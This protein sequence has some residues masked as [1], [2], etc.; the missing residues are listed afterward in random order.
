MS[1]LSDK[2]AEVWT[3]ILEV[4]AEIAKYKT[5]PFP[6]PV[7]NP[8]AS[9]AELAALEQHLGQVL[10][11][12]YREFLSLHNGVK[13]F[14]LDMPLLA[15]HEIIADEHGWVEDLAEEE[16]ELAKFYIAG[17]DEANA[18]YLVFDQ[19]VRSADGEMEV[20]HL[21]LRLAQTR[22]PSFL[23]MLEDR[24]KRSNRRLQAE[25]ADREQLE[26]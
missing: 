18:G 8:P 11:P 25:R 12:L 7:S 20:V 15:T 3:S 26:D 24:L 16:P 13:N 17:S 2:L 4:E 9:G 21:T 5:T 10:P 14:E 23:Q 1:L 6:P 22:W 19:R